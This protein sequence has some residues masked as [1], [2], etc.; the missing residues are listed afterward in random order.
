[1]NASAPAAGALR[2]GAPALPGARLLYG[3]AAVFAVGDS[4]AAAGGVGAG[5][6]GGAGGRCELG[7]DERRYCEESYGAFLAVHLPPPPPLRY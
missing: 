3:G 2:R 5:G 4:G 1:V 6:A 7:G